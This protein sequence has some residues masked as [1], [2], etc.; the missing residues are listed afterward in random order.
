MKIICISDTHNKHEELELPSGDCIVHAG[1]FT[2]AGTKKESI[3]FLEW[4]SKTPYKHKILIAG[5]HDFYFQKKSHKLIQTIPTNIHYLEDSGVTIENINFW[6][7]PYTPGDNTWAFTKD[8]GR[9]LSQHWNKI[10]KKTNVLITHSPPFGV[11]DELDNKTMVGCKNLIERLSELDITHH[12]FGHV[13]NDYGK[14][15]TE[16]TTFIN[17][18]SIDESYRIIN[19]PISIIYRQHSN[20]TV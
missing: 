19:K 2:E 18:S 7:S 13:H 6:G 14:V 17:S 15:K 8:R 16:R 5:N 3:N 1:D 4:F 10:P 12:I 11:L 20:I 9:P